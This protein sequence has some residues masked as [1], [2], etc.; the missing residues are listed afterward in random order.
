MK[1]YKNPATG[2]VY[3]YELDGSQDAVIPAEFEAISDA[4]ADQIRES[5][6]PKIPRSEIIRAR[7]AEIDTQ[8]IRALRATIAALGKNKPL[9]A[10]DVDRLTALD[11]EAVALR[12]ERAAL[13]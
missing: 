11:T 3:G 1:H 6:A 4:E 2:D 7:L 10:A 8:S 12:A 5:K 13:A 9:P